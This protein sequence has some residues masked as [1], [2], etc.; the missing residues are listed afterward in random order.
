[1][2][3][4]D[5]EA[6]APEAVLGRLT[7]PELLEAVEVLLLG[8]A[9]ALTRVEVAERAGVPIDVAEQLWHCS[10]S[11]APDDDEVVFTEADLQAL[12]QTMRLIDAGILDED[13]QA[14]MVRTWGRSFARLAEWQTALLASLAVAADDPEAKLEELAGD[15]VPPRVTRCRAT[16]GAGTWPARRAGCCC[17]RPTRSRR[18]RRSGSWTSSATPRQSRSLS[19]PDLVALVEHFE[20]V[21]ARTVTDH[22]GRL[23]KTIGDEVLYVADTPADGRAHRP[24]PGRARRRGRRG[25]PARAGGVAHGPVVS[26]L[27]DVFG[28]TVNIASRLTSLSRPGKVLVDKGM[29]DAL[30]ELDPDESEFRLSRVRRTSV[31][32]YS[33]IEPFRLKSPR[34]HPA[35]TP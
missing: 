21:A 11:R 23:I 12:K 6:G 32:G 18:C 22:G 15:V 24:D 9:P 5:D 8:G 31:K 16:S 33:R 34:K 3:D 25:L 1:M 14:A 17:G 26:R 28:P 29:R 35:R 20:E 4:E 27:G 7:G 2:A 30:A 10:A 19:D 13:S